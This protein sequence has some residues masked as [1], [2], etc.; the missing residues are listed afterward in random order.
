MNTFTGER[1]WSVDVTPDAAGRAE[2]KRLGI[3]NKLR[4]PKDT[5]TR[6]ETFLSFRQKEFH[7]DKD[8]NKVANEPITIKD[9]QGNAWS[10]GLIGNGT[11]ADVKFTIRDYGKGKPKGVYIQ[12]IRI[13]DLVPYEVQEFAPLSEDDEYFASGTPSTEAKNAPEEP[14]TESTAEEPDLDDD[15]PF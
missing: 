8:G 7:L 4:E 12:A 1:D 9:G 15:V 10:G 13:L 5:D 3:T 6:K 11:I 2:L 14:A